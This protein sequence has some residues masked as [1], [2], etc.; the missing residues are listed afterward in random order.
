[1][2]GPINQSVSPG[3]EGFVVTFL[4]ACAL[5]LLMRNM[6][7]RLRNMK[8]R[9]EAEEERRAAQDRDGRADTRPSAAGEKVP[10]ERVPG[11]KV[12]GDRTSGDGPDARAGGDRR[13]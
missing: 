5:W 7:T 3:I 10:G 2:G 12:P 6:S 8:Y 11:E 13:S 9:E 4:I 1:M